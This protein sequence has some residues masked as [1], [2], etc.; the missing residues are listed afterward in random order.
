MLSVLRHRDEPGGALGG[1]EQ[2]LG[3]R[4]EHAVAALELRA[5]HREIGL[6][7]EL[8]R[9]GA[10]LR[11]ASDA[12]RDR[13]PDRLAGGLDVEVPLGDGA[14]NP[15]GDLERLLG[16]RLG[17]EDRELFAAETRGDVVVAQLG[18]EDLRDSLQHRVAGKVAVVVVDVAEQVEVGHDQGQRAL[19]ALGAPELLLQRQREVARVEESR[20]RID[21]RL[22]LQRR[23][24]E[25]A[26]HEQDWSDGERQK[27]RIVEPEVRERDAERR[28][29]ELRGEVLEAE[30]ARLPDR[31]PAREIQHHC[32]QRVVD[33]HE[34][35]AGDEAGDGEPEARVLN[36]AAVFDQLR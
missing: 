14:A 36:P 1:H 33:Q 28:E 17:Q 29:H 13:G 2:R 22:G 3:A 24:R 34:Y 10:V 23:H 12:D 31:V 21:A 20:L 26:V 25:R 8:V 35:Q 19:E 27:P 5:V 4:A 18:A 7:D 15:L 9:I 32:E 16:R 30:Q 11:I 6:V